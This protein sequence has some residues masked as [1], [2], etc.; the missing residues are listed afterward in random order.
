MSPVRTTRDGCARP[1]HWN[2]RPRRFIH[3]RVGKPSPSNIISLSVT[4][5]VSEFVA[6]VNSV[7]RF[8]DNFSGR[9]ARNSQRE[10]SSKHPSEFRNSMIGSRAD[11]TLI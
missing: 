6:T 5:L 2:R 3:C 9:F 1:S 4:W 11:F 10:Q 7:V 8:H